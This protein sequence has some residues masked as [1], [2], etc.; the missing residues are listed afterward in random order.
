MTVRTHG[1][2]SFA[3]E[4]QSLCRRDV[5]AC[6]GAG[7]ASA[8]SPVASTQSPAQSLVPLTVPTSLQPVGACAFACAAGLAATFG[9]VF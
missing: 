7:V 4:D 3:R 9:C 8:L 2:R 5:R 6:Y 1:S